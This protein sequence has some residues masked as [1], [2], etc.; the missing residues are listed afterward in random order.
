M[1]REHGTKV[2]DLIDEE[3]RQKLLKLCPRLRF[4]GRKPV[5]RKKAAA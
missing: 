2:W 4:I 5:R 1:R 3:S